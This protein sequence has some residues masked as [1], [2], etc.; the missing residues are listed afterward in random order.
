MF[1][2]VALYMF[3]GEGVTQDG[4]ILEAQGFWPD[5]HLHGMLGQDAGRGRSCMQH[6]L[7]GNQQLQ[8]KRV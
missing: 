8:K 6:T 2:D 3:R 5:S 4:Y 1:H 7:G